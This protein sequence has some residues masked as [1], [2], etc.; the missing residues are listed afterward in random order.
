MVCLISIECAT[1]YGKKN[2]GFSD[3]DSVFFRNEWHTQCLLDK[4]WETF[5]S[6]TLKKNI[7]CLK[8]TKSYL[9]QSVSETLLC[10]EGQQKVSPC[11]VLHRVLAHVENLDVQITY[12]CF[13]TYLIASCH[14][15][16]AP[17]V[18]LPMVS[19]WLGYLG[20]KM[21]RHKLR[22]PLARHAANEYGGWVK[23][24]W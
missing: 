22:I 8:F 16:T 4:L 20:Y 18:Y 6:H 7:V 17:V 15:V 9:H 14:S 21:N 10:W 3:S 13:P 23:K 19:L 5:F 24:F 12:I 11:V 1:N 2:S